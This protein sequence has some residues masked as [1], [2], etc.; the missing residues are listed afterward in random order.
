MDLVPF[1]IIK[2]YNPYLRQ[3]QSGTGKTLTSKPI[4]Q[5]SQE[6]SISLRLKPKEL[7]MTFP[8]K[9]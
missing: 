3:V 7:I 5:Y 6:V 2:M 1:I 8:V 9:I 4:I